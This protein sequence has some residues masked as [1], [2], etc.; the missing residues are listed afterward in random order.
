M[1]C[2]GVR[3]ATTVES[4]CR[5]DILEETRKLLALM[6]RFNDIKHRHTKVG[7]PKTN[8]V[9]ERFNR[10]VLDEFFRTA[11]R[12]KLYDSVA[13]LQ[14]D[15]DKWLNHYNYERPHRGYRNQG[16]RPIE[17]FEK[18]LKVREQ[19]KKEAS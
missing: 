12:K 19:I 2:R 14:E 13:A 4:N 3:G 8:G 11:F 5:D 7:N 17:T 9:V 1:S 10:T 18:G 15:L 6:I 16:R